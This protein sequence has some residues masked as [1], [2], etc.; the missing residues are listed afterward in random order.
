MVF[1]QKKRAVNG[2]YGAFYKTEWSLYIQQDKYF[3]L[4]ESSCGDPKY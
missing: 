3:V 2:I 1:C 4:F